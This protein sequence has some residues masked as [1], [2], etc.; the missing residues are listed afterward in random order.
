MISERILKQLDS[1][2]LSKRTIKIL[3]NRTKQAVQDDDITQDGFGDLYDFLSDKLDESTMNTLWENREKCSGCGKP[4]LDKGEEGY[5]GMYCDYDCQE[6]YEE[7]LRKCDRC[8]TVF[9]YEDEGGYVMDESA[10]SIECAERIITDNCPTAFRGYDEEGTIR[11][12]QREADWPW[13]ENCR[14]LQRDIERFG[15]ELACCE[16]CGG[17]DSPDEMI[18]ISDLGETLCGPECGTDRIETYASDEGLT[19]NEIAELLKNDID[20][21][22]GRGDL[23]SAIRDILDKRPE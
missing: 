10:C 3:V 20:S 8:G 13:Y 15:V 16:S 22:S 7:F 17:Y 4:V 23:D 2:G 12:L 5:R 14:T 19:P 9:D 6:Q 18:Y 11:N 21:L 1:T